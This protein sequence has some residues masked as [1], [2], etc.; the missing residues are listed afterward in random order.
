MTNILITGG[1]G[2]IGSHLATR[3]VELDH[4][5]TV[6]DDLSTGH[7]E[8]LTHL[9][10]RYTLIE[11]D[12]CDPKVCKDACRDVEIVFHQAAIPSVPK[13]VK[14]PERSHAANINGTFNVLNACVHAK[15]RRFIFAASSSA[16]GETVESPKHE[17]IRPEPLS[18]Y[19]VQKCTCEHYARAFYECYGLQ[20]LSLRYFN[21]F[22]VRQDPS[23]GYAAAIPAFVTA[24]LRGERPTVFG[25]GEQTRDFTYIDNVVLANELAMNVDKAVGNVVNVACGE[26]ITINR[27]LEAINKALGT[28]IEPNYTAER[29]GDVRH[30][31]A[32]I[33]LARK[34]LGFAPKVSFE[35]GLALAIEYYR[36]VT[37][38]D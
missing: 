35:Q 32:D 9:G 3:M 10:D 17:G 21:V 8:N 28:D 31:S 7:R 1:A 11:G 18:P 37:S 15:V 38:T 5:V 30:S 13:S 19:A 26:P 2:F 36:S 24:M 16:Y 34:L 27:V 25:D 33:S 23:S 6:L 20:T 14:D 4:R 12:M 22:G 29:P